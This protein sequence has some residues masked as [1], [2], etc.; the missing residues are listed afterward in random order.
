[1]RAEPQRL[2]TRLEVEG[3]SGDLARGAEA[4]RKSYGEVGRHL[5]EASESA[6]LVDVLCE[7]CPIV[8]ATEGFCQLSGHSR[9]FL[10]GQ[11]C[12][13]MLRGVPEVAISKSARKN[14]RDFCRMCRLYGLERISETWSLQANARSDGSQFMNF[15]MVGLCLVRGHPY[16]MGVQAPVGEGLSVRLSKARLAEVNEQSRQVMHRLQALI[17]R[18]VASL[19]P[20]EPAPP[21]EPSHTPWTKEGF[22]DTPGPG[23]RFY[24][25]RL[26]DH[27]LLFGDSRVAIR[28][29]PHELATNCLVLGD[30]PVR[31]TSIGLWFA[32]RIDDVV[33]TFE[34]LPILGF[35]RRKP[36]DSPDL[37]PSVAKCFG[38][39]VL[40]GGCGEAF[41]RDQLEHFNIGFKAP[42]S[43]EVESWAV[44]PDLPPHKRKAPFQVKPGD[45]LG[46]LYTV[47]GHIQLW[48]NGKL[49]LN[50]DTLRPPQLDADY[51]AVVDVA[52][53]VYSVIL[54][55]APAPTCVTVPE[56]SLEK[57]KPSPGTRLSRDVIEEAMKAVV[58]EC[59]YS[60]SVGDPEKSG[61]P[62]IAVSSAFEG[63]TG[64]SRKD[65]LGTNCR[66]LNEGSGISEDD[67]DGMRK[68]VRTGMSFV[69]LLPNR[70]KSGQMFVNLLDLQ[71]HVLARRS[72][73]GVLWYSVGI[74]AD[75]TGVHKTELP[76]SGLA[77]HRH[78][79]HLVYE[80]L[81]QEVTTR[82]VSSSLPAEGRGKLGGE[83]V[84]ELVEEPL[85]MSELEASCPFANAVSQASKLEWQPTLSPSVMLASETPENLRANSSMPLLTAASRRYRVV[86][87]DEFRQAYTA[88]AEGTEE[89]QALDLIFTR[90]DRLRRF[91][92]LV[93]AV[94]L[95]ALLGLAVLMRR[96]HKQ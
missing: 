57:V 61:V 64:Y 9:E 22:R 26:Q 73:G 37:Y 87:F 1:M 35:T 21:P 83:E 43:C 62:L 24:S 27:C 50:F 25:G 20:I 11:N 58:A 80:R 28:R 48:H 49:S 13:C 72:D 46:C 4:V 12:R 69:G 90:G 91:A 17:K 96:R 95:G 59:G 75:V 93:P 78:L 45:T 53:T 77:H 36:T 89:P 31:C 54:V 94:T 32:V 86:D 92:F 74:Q 82:A 52:F 42:K 63:V 84:F 66:F 39:S 40:V 76:E 51:Y 33:G 2:A 79:A 5:D 67:Q 23:F 44:N 29:E 81:K 19:P 70:K 6:L 14:L 71:G 47:D 15:F 60:V 30:A 55:D 16:V 56:V 8:G 85:L 41:A 88:Q 3:V 18:E 68:A 38:A 34:G 10:L 65:V 7:D